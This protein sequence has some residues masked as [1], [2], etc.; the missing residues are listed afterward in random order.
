LVA[1]SSRDQPSRARAARSCAG[2]SI[3]ALAGDRSIASIDT[4]LFGVSTPLLGIYYLK[5]VSHTRPQ[6]EL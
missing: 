4:P 2:V 5:T 1:S 3:P 6:S